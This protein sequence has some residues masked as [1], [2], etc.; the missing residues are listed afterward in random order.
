[1]EIIAHEETRGALRLR[2]IVD[3]DPINPRKDFDHEGTV[4]CCDHRRYTLG[5]DDAHADAAEMIRASRDYRPSWEDEDGKAL[6]FSYGP[7]LWAAIQLCSD[8]VALPCY[9]Y[10]HSGLT[11]STGRF[12][13][14]WDSGQVGFIAMAKPAILEAQCKPKGSRLSSFLKQR[15]AALLKAEVAEY[16][17]YLRGDVYGYVVDRVDGESLDDMDS[18]CWGFF[19][20][21][22]ATEEGREA[23]EYIAGKRPDLA[24]MTAD[25]VEEME[26]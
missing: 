8:I 13:C 5:D 15:T 21:D 16:D 24:N 19:G 7:D 9:L 4:M 22:Y 25:Q 11:M 20:L 17:Q 18:S 6:D 2:I 1:M 23:L 3:A 14:P 12:S 10:D 26:G